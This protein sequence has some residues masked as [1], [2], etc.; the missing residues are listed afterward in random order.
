MKRR[1]SVWAVEYLLLFD[2]SAGS[3]QGNSIFSSVQALQDLAAEPRAGSGDDPRQF[4]S[5]PN[6]LS[7]L[8]HA[9]A[10]GSDS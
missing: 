9:Y 1:K 4:G 3:C 6:S 7:Q 2:E 10:T 5:V 8:Q